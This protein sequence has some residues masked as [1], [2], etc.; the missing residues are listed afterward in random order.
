MKAVLTDER[1]SDPDW[2]FERKL[3]GI[4]C[5]AIRVGP[6]LR[7]LSRNDLSLNE[8]YPELAEA[9]AAQ[10]RERFAVDGEVVAFDGAARA[11]PSSPSAGERRERLLL[12][13][14]PALARRTRRPAAA[15]PLAQAAAARRAEF[16]GPA[17]PHAAPQPRRRGALRGGLPQGLGGPDRQAGRQ[18]LHERALARL[19]E[20]QVRPLP[21]DGDRRLHP[22]EGLARGAGGAAARLPRRRRLPLRRQGG[23]R[24]HPRDAADLAGKL[25]AAAPRRSRRSPTRMRSRSAA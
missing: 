8:R 24:L 5:V 11:S 4:R 23:H 15:A 22:A 19:A 21:G 17:A 13:V 2:I 18:P 9:L 3:D 7:L 14:R 6:R 25:R 16:H 10:S 1:F 12:R 20:V